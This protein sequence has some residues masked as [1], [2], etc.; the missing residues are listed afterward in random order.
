VVLAPASI[1]F[2]RR[3]R[4]GGAFS[5]NK[6]LVLLMYCRR[7]T[8]APPDVP[9]HD[10]SRWFFCGGT[11][12]AWRSRSVEVAVG[13]F[14]QPLEGRPGRFVNFHIQNYFRGL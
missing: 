14:P 6:K 10:V 11:V 3:L 4:R 2:A 1:W 12:R 9:A 5:Y 13:D 7:L 8:S